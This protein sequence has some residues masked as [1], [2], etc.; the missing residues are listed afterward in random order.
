MAPIGP[1]LVIDR[2]RRKGDPVSPLDL[3]L[4]SLAGA[5]AIVA[6]GLALAVATVALARALATVRSALQSSPHNEMGQGLAA[7]AENLSQGAAG[8]SRS[9]IKRLDSAR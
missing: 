6:I 8:A 9:L 7:L 1:G 3:I 4:W 5:G 2:P